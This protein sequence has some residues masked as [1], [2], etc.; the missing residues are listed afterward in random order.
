MEPKVEA[1]V[2]SI[3]GHAQRPDSGHLAMGTPAVVE[4]SHA[5]RRVAFF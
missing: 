4:Q 1:N 3:G 2:A 5:L